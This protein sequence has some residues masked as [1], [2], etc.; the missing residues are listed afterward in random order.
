MN[1]GNGTGDQGRHRDRVPAR[2]ADHASGEPARVQSGQTL[3]AIS[4]S[5][6]GSTSQ[7]TVGGGGSPGAPGRRR[8][9][10]LSNAATW[11]GADA[12]RIKQ[13]RGML[14]AVQSSTSPHS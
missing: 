8:R 9:H 11:R 10:F 3:L 4:G 14:W 7:F 13:L 12:G 5:G 2:R 1:S 6:D